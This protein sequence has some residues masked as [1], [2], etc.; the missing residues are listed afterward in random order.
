MRR[1]TLF[2]LL[3]LLLLSVGGTAAQQDTTLTPAETESPTTDALSVT[4]ILPAD[5]SNGVETDSTITVIFNRPV[6]PLGVSED[7]DTLPQPLSFS[8]TVSGQGE[9][10]N[11]SIY[12]FHPDPALQGGTTYSVT[13]DASLTAVDGAQLSGAYSWSFTTVTPTISEVVPRDG[14][15]GVALDRSLQV[16]FNQPMDQAS[17]EA[18]FSLHE[19]GQPASSKVA[20]TF[21]WSGD[22]AGFRFIPDAD[23]RIGTRYSAEFTGNLPLP[24][25][26]GTALEGQTAWSFEAVPYPMVIN[27]DP[28]DGE[29]GVYPY[30]GFRIYF[31]SPM[32]PD[33]LRDH[34][35]ISP[36]P[37]RDFDTYYSDYD[38]SYSLSY[39]T[40]ASTEYTVTITAGMEDVYGNPT[41]EGRVVH[42]ATAPYDPE[43]NLQVPGEIGFYNAYNDQTR[44]FLTHLN[45][46]KI[47]LSLY[48]VAQDSLVGALTGEHYYNAADA[49]Q[50]GLSNRLRTW[51]IQSVAPPDMRRYELL[52]LGGSAIDC[53]GAPPSRVRVGD[54]AIVTSDPDPLRARASAPDGTVIDSLYKDYALPITG[55][56]VCA[57]SMLWWEVTLRDGQTAWVAEGISGAAGDEYFI[58]LRDAA[59]QTPVVITQ[60]D[61]EALN[62]GLYL[63]TA[64]SPETERNGSQA[65]KHVL[66]VAT[67]NLTLKYS[68]GSLMVWATDVNTGEPIAN[69]PISIFGSGTR[70]I[71][72]GVTDAEGLLKLDV[73]P[74]ENLYDPRIAVLKTNDQFGIASTDWSDGLDSWYFGING[75]YSPEDYRGYL[76]TDRPIYRPDQPVYFRGVVRA[77]DD[78]TYTPPDF[79]NISVTIYDDQ[80]E[81]VY[82]QDLPLT[83]YGTF[84]SEFDLA[85]DASLGNYRIV[86]TLPGEEENYYPSTGVINF[87][88]AE[89][90]APEFQV[91]VT[92]Q[93]GEVVQGDTINVVVDSTYFF[94]GAVGGANVEYN[95]TAQPYS[96][97]FTG[98]GYYSFEDFNADASPGEFYGSGDYGLVTSG[99]GV[100][101]V[102]GHLTISFPADLQDATMS[103][104]FTIE[105]TVT[106]ASDQAVSGRTSVVVHQGLWYVGVQPQ[107][108]VVTSG[109]E[110]GANLILVDWESQPIAGQPV[111]VDVVERRWSSVQEED[112]LGRTTWT[113]EV[114]EI[115]VTSGGVTTDADGK[116]VFNFTPPNGGIFKIT[117][118]TRDPQGN[119]IVASNSIWVSSREYVTWRQQNSNRI[120]LVADAKD[121]SVGDT[122]EILIASPFQ[123]TTEALITVERGDVL[124]AEH[125]TMTSNS[126]V[127]HLP[128]TD[129]DVPNVFVSVV[130][131]KGVDA[132]NPVAAFRMGLVQLNVGNVRREINVAIST[133]TEQAGPGD[134]LDYT[135]KTTDF[136]GNAVQAEVGVSLTDLA[137]LTI[138]DPNSGKLLDTFYGLQGDS[139]R[140]ST[141]LTINVDQITQTVLDT[142][143][144]G[145]GGFGEG[146]IFDIRQEFVD[147]PYW[148]ASIVTGA[149]GTA[150]FSVTL[151]DN[152][153]TWRLDARAVT[154]GSA[155]EPMLVGQNTYDLISTKPVLIRPVTPRF[156]V[157]GD[158]VSLGAVVNNNSGQELSVDVSLQSEGVTFGANTPATQTVQIAAGQQARVD[159]WVTV[160]DVANVDLTFFASG[161]DG[162]YTDASKPPLGQG[163]ARTLPVYQY[164]VP[165]T[166][167]TG[168]V[169]RE[170]GDRTEGI[171]LPQNMDVTQG[172]LD[173]ELDP[174]LAA[175]TI[176][177]LT[178]LQNYPYQC[179]EQTV[180]RFLPNI[181]T[182]RALASLKLDDA[183]LKA[184]LDSNVSFALQRLYAEQK[185]DGGW[186]WFVQDASNPLTTA[187]ALIGLSEAQAQGFN[188]S[189]EAIRNAR[190]FLR[191]GFIT[192]GLNVETWQ[193]NRQAFV[194]YALARAGDPDVARTT[195]LYESRDRL[196]DYAKVFLALTFHIIDA[197]DPSRTD[198][199]MSDLV[200]SAA[201]SATGAH[202]NED[203]QDYWNWNTDTR[204]TA[205][206]LEA[207]V[208]IMPESDLIPN[209]VRYLMV[210]RRADSW[211]TTQ[212]TAWAVMSLTDWMVV[213]GEL[214]PNYSYSAE[215]N[216]ESLAQD[217]V[218]QADVR[219]SINLQVQVSDMLTDQVN[220]L[221]I[222][223]TDGDGV[224][225]YTAHL[226]VF[227][228]V[229]QVEPLDHGLIVERRYTMAGS[230]EPVTSAQVGDTLQVRLTV[231]APNDLHYVIIED[232]I[233]AGADAVDPNLNT[234]QQIGTQPELNPANPLSQ[235]WGWWYFSNI[236][237]RDEKVV[238]YSTYLPAGTY[239]YVYS[240][241]AGLVGEYN[242]IP[243][244]GYEFYFPEVYG[245]GAGSS[246]TIEAAQ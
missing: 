19:Q 130:L 70:V 90:R 17:V 99:E 123:G 2:A 73:P 29:M 174:S 207:L 153:T 39:P 45:V 190:N 34:V 43:V 223:R 26:G 27:T 236:E 216:G 215:F 187:Y 152:L 239:E 198:V 156:F 209:V 145:G 89:Y 81:V 134:T 110:T 245:R 167:G 67:A 74:A 172:Q 203:H 56:P 117:A 191:G 40:D 163:D 222:G 11:T 126:Y 83:P 213:S 226:R 131:V 75:N 94:G 80:N 106:D 88:V 227:L 205:I 28:A 113:Y 120:D 72:S 202:W 100:T 9:W 64:T 136:E 149:D 13:V 155:D 35:T 168:G 107:E 199:L 192:P 159:W 76:Y 105:A 3:A 229:P 220:S 58:D 214:N 21:D 108:Y 234:S 116:A 217:A 118:K 54:A 20:G 154:A 242:V 115:P 103:Q 91:D 32:N 144:G 125:I 124:K 51:S 177:G 160:D 69:A 101:D 133:D 38:N 161:N 129:E 183:D 71:A 186:G 119:A 86:A 112:E 230:S 212:E 176:D 197:N 241:R 225:Y 24:E 22:G 78:V 170:G 1:I 4:Q 14:A 77:Q 210:E 189:S 162:A 200:N 102:D 92:Q 204:T 169:L 47:D 96:F 132:N 206:V 148:N 211:E 60:A 84:S 93:Q 55:G 49:I 224:L 235:G 128:I 50:T 175:T 185:V 12:V 18:S 141:P 42:Y 231:I 135:V 62:P 181:M 114:E 233:P 16:R 244:T 228:P 109:S 66:I 52:N 193:L 37:Q 5:G 97:A 33:T 121:Y 146:G 95:V 111:A 68:M 218:T 221:V 237:F 184:Q 140:T 201:I 180:S 30:G 165:E 79:T 232:P 238:L 85:T 194:L 48:S 6:V 53:P 150:T 240:I 142:I 59:A 147:T 166:V 23:L 7:A 246:F 143:K 82:Q 171:S 31:A 219:E 46:S 158:Q 122:A 25:G 195:T 87:S 44:L 188:V 157:V 151:P 41:K 137:V 139:V 8:P 10:L 196:S 164:E 173:V 15:S 138:S 61:G 36:E 182:Y 63:L 208:E 243:P 98:D 127:Y 179:V 65:R 104:T 178:Y 57:N